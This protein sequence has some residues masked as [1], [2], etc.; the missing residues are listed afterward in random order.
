MR[1]RTSPEVPDPADT[2]LVAALEAAIRDLQVAVAELSGVLGGPEGETALRLRRLEQRLERLEDLSTV[3]VL[4]GAASEANPAVGEGG[5][6]AP[7]QLVLQPGGQPARSSPQTGEASR[8]QQLERAIE[9]DQRRGA[10]AKATATRLGR[11]A[12]RMPPAR[13]EA[14]CDRDNVGLLGDL[15]ARGG[16]V[17]VHVV[18]GGSEPGLVPSALF[19]RVDGAVYRRV[20][21][22]DVHR[23]W[24]HRGVPGMGDSPEEVA[25]ALSRVLAEYGHA[26]VL[27]LGAG[28]AGFAAI[29]LGALMGAD[30]VVAVDAPTTLDPS[31]LAEFG[32]ARWSSDLAVLDAFGGARAEYL[33]LVPVLAE[34][35]TQVELVMGALNPVHRLH[36]DRLGA[37]SCVSIVSLE[38]DD[39]TAWL[40]AEDDRIAELLRRPLATTPTPSDYDA[41]VP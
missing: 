21:V 24:L 11:G 20:V 16:M 28:A 7:H 38:V 3:P 36:A 12:T 18:E 22:R 33:D 30:H 25:D 4:P 37:V 6:P 2:A 26:P 27:L 9:R 17:L 1:R 40:L 34:R 35:S 13:L 19:R 41:P 15:D 5:A 10:R 23:S 29:I 31:V 14:V 39:A 8:A 32:D